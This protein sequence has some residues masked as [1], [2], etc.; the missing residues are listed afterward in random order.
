LD[1]QATVTLSNGL[2]P[3]SYLWSNGGSTATVS[4]LAA[5]SYT[6]SVS[7]AVNCQVEVQVDITEP[8]ELTASVAE[9]T[10]AA[11]G[12]TNGTVSV[13]ATGGTGTLSY[14]W[15]NGATTNS[16]ENLAPGSYS[17]SVS[18]EN[19][20]SA[21]LMVVVSVED[22]EAPVV[23]TQDIT[24][25]LGADGTASI[26]PDQVDNGSS[27]NCAIAS[28]T[29]DVSSFDCAN[30]GNNEVSLTVTDG[31]GNH[32]AATATVTVVDNSLPQIALQ[33]ITLSLDA[34]GLATLEA[35]MIDNGSS[36]NCGIVSMSIDVSSFDCSQLGD[37]PVVLTIA[38]A[39]G[40]QTSGTAVVT[41]VDDTAPITSCPENMVL[42][43]C[44]PVAFYVVTATD[45]CSDLLSYQFP[46]DYPSGATFPAGIT[47]LEVSVSDSEGNTATCQFSV[48]VPESMDPQVSGNPIL[49]AGKD[50]GA[51]FAEPTGGN[52]A[53]SF[54]WNTGATTASIQDLGP[55]TYEVTVTD[56]DGCTALGSVTLTAP[57]AVESTLDLLV[58]ESGSNQDGAIAVT[59]SGGVAPYSFAWIDGQGSVISDEEDI[60]GLSAGNYSL[61][62]TDANGCESQFSYTIQSI[63]K[64]NDELLA[65]RLS[66]YPNPSNGE[67]TLELADVPASKVALTVFDVHGKV[68][69]LQP[70]TDLSA[71]RCTVDL[72]HA[73]NGIY[74]VRIMVN[75]QVVSKRLMINRW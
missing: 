44:D 47:S 17:L 45:N 69:L 7:D 64:V 39:A 15:S 40:N 29:L 18:D 68:V 43:S 54:A 73:A 11:C 22:A 38:D 27:D 41:V 33:N 49:C 24:V 9:L 14:Q 1:G 57:E 6:V 23:V 32:S 16:L 62:V 31:A 25:T 74:L 46:A 21:N 30:L 48:S 61:F 2:S 19:D 72:T 28:L 75:D 34:A 10:P 35:A 71:G 4:N 59:I 20:C 42:P 36:D 67:V 51:A 66:L 53:Y 55:G 56:A 12:E 52:P 65:A 70:S 58:N 3:F 63:V 26:Q 8:A 37:H 5:G 50:N 60:N 13:D